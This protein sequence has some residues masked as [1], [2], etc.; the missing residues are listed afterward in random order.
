MPSQTKRSDLSLT[1]R[2][3][4]ELTPAALLYL[5]KARGGGERRKSS[6]RR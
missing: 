3:F 4:F 5:A 1:E 2:E 6:S